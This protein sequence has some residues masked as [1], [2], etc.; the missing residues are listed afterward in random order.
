M[1]KVIRDLGEHG[2]GK[3]RRRARAVL[4]APERVEAAGNMEC[5]GRVGRRRRMAKR[6]VARRPCAALRKLSP[7]RV[8]PEVYLTYRTSRQAFFL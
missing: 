1:Q 4:D 6:R 2:G 8:I 3:A 7:P 5:G